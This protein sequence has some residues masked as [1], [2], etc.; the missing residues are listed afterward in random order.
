VKSYQKRCAICALCAF[1]FPSFK[2]IHSGATLN[3]GAN[4]TID[5]ADISASGTV[6]AMAIACLVFAQRGNS[7]ASFI[8]EADSGRR[9]RGR[10]TLSSDGHAT[11]FFMH[12]GTRD[13]L[14][15]SK[16]GATRARFVML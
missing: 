8:A 15:I 9:L 12:L 16:T 1:F 6:I 5:I 4:R 7:A 14:W 13:L 10:Y 2:H 11:E 3:S